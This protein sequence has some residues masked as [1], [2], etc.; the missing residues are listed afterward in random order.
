[1]ATPNTAAVELIDPRR[2]QKNSDNP[3]LIFRQDELKAL[4]D[5][6][7]D[8]GILVPLTVFRDGSKFTLLDGERRWRC[9]L[10]LG[11]HQ[12]PAIVQA[13]PD[14]VTNIM[15]MFA[16]HNARQ[17]WDPLPAALKLEELEKILQKAHGSPP[18]E[19]QLA[20]AASLSLG[21]VRRFKKI[22]DLPGNIRDQLMHELDKP[23]S[24]QVLTVDHGIEAV[25]GATRLAKSGA[26]GE[27]ERVALVRT[28]VSKFRSKILQSTIEPRKLSRIA[29]AVERDEISPNIVQR[30]IRKFNASPNYTIDDVFRETVENTDF[31]HGTEQLIRRSLARLDQMRSRDI[32]ATKELKDLLV[33]FIDRAKLFIK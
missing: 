31:S 5:S 6:I 32:S 4:E 15:M 33:Q 21:V 1:M 14:R 25:A 17:D 10:R 26:I 20:A 7:R 29:R 16:I 28:I 19:K 13:R 18:S 23:R 12:V 30:Q 27:T 2:L 3:R 11:L 9:A 8:Q 22:L 24:E